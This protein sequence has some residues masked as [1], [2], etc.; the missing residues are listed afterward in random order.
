MRSRA[1][2]AQL[3]AIGTVS[4]AASANTICRTSL[5]TN[6]LGVSPRAVAR[7][8]QRPSDRDDGPAKSR[9]LCDHAG[10]SSKPAR[11]FTNRSSDLYTLPR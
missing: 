8:L 3:E 7:D 4:R 9:S 2:A 6:E 11:D 5:L 10:R 1:V